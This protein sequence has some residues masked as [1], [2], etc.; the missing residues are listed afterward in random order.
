MGGRTTSVAM[1]MMLAMVWAMTAAL[2]SASCTTTTVVHEPAPPPP[3]LPVF[4]DDLAPHGDWWWNETYGWVW[5]P[6]VSVAWRPYTVGHWVWTDDAGW[7][8]VSHEPYGA[9][10]FHYGRWVW[11]DDAGWV[12][13]PGRV[14]APA[15]V[16]WRTG[17]GFIGW[18][19]LGPGAVWVPGRGFV[20]ADVTVGVTAWG[21]VFVEEPAFMSPDVVVVVWPRARNAHVLER[22]RVTHRPEHEDGRVV[23]R[24]VPPEDVERVVGRPIER[25]TTRDARVE[26]RPDVEGTERTRDGD[27]RQPAREERDPAEARGGAPRDEDAEVRP[28]RTRDEDLDLRYEDE[29]K[30]AIERHEIERKNPPPGVAADELP[31]RQ[32]SELKGIDR[33]KE[34]DKSALQK[35]KTTPRKTPRKTPGKRS[36]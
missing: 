33:E 20:V 16:V 28:L 29:R 34:R 11:I 18:A 30:R 24:S 22:T 15:W 36:R 1:R 25:T 9:I 26:R 10:V 2:A 17:P 3:P 23:N 35:K 13:I 31:R 19:P 6:D 12:W 4:H 8:W 21:W 5:S 7:L 32:E 14:W 27:A